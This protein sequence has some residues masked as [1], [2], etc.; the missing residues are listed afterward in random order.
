MIWTAISYFLPE[1]VTFIFNCLFFFFLYCLPPFL[2]FFSSE[3]Q[4]N[5]QLELNF[6]TFF[7][8]QRFAFC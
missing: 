1:N 4:L 5:L 6:I 7:L 3:D 8:M 2:C